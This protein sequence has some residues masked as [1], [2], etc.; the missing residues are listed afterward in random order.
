MRRLVLPIVVIVGFISCNITEKK[1]EV[2]TPVANAYQPSLN[3]INEGAAMVREGDLLVRNGSDFTSQLIKS[4]SQKDKNYSHSGLVF[5]KEGVP[6]VYHILAGDENP[7]GKLVPD[8]FT[9]FCN[10][11][12]NAG[13]A[14]YRYNMD[15]AEVA[16][17]KATIMDWLKQGIRFDS[18]FSLKTDDRMYCSEMVKKGLAKATNNRINIATRKPSEGEVILA[19]ARLPLSAAYMKNLDLVPIDNLYINSSCTLVRAFNF[20][21]QK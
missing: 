1:P 12:Y 4:F 5:F 18:A 11:R 2:A 13:F 19:K 8:S 17:L 16:T 6:Y 14:I 10:P 3:Q 9:T 15:A 7:D 21:H 20:N